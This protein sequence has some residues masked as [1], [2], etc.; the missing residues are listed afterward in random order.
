MGCGSAVTYN[1]FFAHAEKCYYSFM[2]P[3]DRSAW[4]P[5]TLTSMALTCASC[6]TD[7]VDGK[8]GGYWYDWC[9]NVT[10]NP[11]PDGCYNADTDIVET[12]NRL[13]DS[14]IQVATHHATDE[15]H[16]TAKLS[17]LEWAKASPHASYLESAAETKTEGKT[18]DGTDTN[19]AIKPDKSV[20]KRDPS[21][22]VT[23]KP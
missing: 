15:E 9:A 18:E 1:D 16:E 11:N 10:I 20:A 17:L 13:S 8:Q 21:L 4:V 12:H 7:G 19:A 14:G 23:P 2:T 5:R 3:I 6:N 22:A